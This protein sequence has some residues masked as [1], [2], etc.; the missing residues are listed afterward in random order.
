MR[1]ED[2]LL[3]ISLHLVRRYDEPEVVE[4]QK[5]EFKLIELCLGETSDLR[6]PRISVKYI[7]EE[8][9]GDCDASNDKSMHVIGVDD[10]R[11][12]CCLRGEARHAVK[13]DEEG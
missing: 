9:T 10:K 1:K 3:G 11:A 4:K 8:F 7:A 13:I 6:I 5:L 12:S 2:K